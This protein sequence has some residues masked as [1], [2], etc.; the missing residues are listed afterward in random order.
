[1]YGVLLSAC[2]TEAILVLRIVPAGGSGE[3]AHEV[4]EAV[5]K[6]ATKRW[7]GRLAVRDDELVEE[8]RRGQ[9]GG[10]R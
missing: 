3:R 4:A 5:L 8:R 9:G 6:E 1:M 10:C 2:G 7:W